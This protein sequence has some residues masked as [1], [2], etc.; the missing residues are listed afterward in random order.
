[1]SIRTAATARAIILSAAWRKA[2]AT[3]TVTTVMNAFAANSLCTDNT[4]NH[5]H[6]DECY[7]WSVELGCGLNEGDGAHTHTEDCYEAE[8]ILICGMEETKPPDRR[9]T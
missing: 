7:E 8:R 1:M 5:I 3:G 9:R 2:R 4:I 6:G